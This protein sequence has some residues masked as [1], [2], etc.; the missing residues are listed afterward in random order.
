MHLGKLNKELLLHSASGD[1][2]SVGVWKLVRLTTTGTEGRQQLKEG[3]GTVSP[4]VGGVYGH[5]NDCCQR[6][7][8]GVQL[9]S[10][11]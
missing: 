10:H 11:L 4:G 6:S 8:S 9:K 2:D 3:Q 5:R 1:S 7:V